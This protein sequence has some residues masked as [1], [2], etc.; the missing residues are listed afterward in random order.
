[1]RDKIQVDA[2]EITQ[3]KLPREYLAVGSCGESVKVWWFEMM[4][5][6]QQKVNE[7]ANVRNVK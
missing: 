1:M 2:P 4:W 3:V 6:M 5:E 7:K